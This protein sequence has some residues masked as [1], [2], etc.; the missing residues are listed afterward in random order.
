MSGLEG[1]SGSGADKR[2]D[3]ERAGAHAKSVREKLLLAVDEILRGDNVARTDRPCYGQAQPNIQTLL[4]HRPIPTSP[5][6]PHNLSQFL[7]N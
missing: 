6:Q 1:S 2:K 5:P 3:E 7:K 4:P